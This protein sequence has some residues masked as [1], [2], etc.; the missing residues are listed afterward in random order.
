MTTRNVGASELLPPEQGKYILDTVEPSL[1]CERMMELAG[2]SGQ[3]ECL[4][5]FNAASAAANTWTHYNEQIFA[6]Y[7]SRGLL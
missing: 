6:A 2:D 4:G 5:A 3:R 7:Q 1:L